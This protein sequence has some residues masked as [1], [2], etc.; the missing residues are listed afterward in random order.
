MNARKRR[1]DYGTIQTTDRD[2]ALLTWIAEQYAI[3]F[4]QL[5]YLVNR[6][7]GEDV[8]ESNIKWLIN[9][10][11]TAGWVDK[12]KIVYG[13]PG[14]IWLSKDGLKAME[15]PYP[16]WEPKPGRMAHIHAVNAVRLFV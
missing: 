14:W 16:Q 1:S 7:K 2:I 11:R 3:R 15:L 13:E 5:H 4:D 10:W 8:T 9:R 12:R 6:Y